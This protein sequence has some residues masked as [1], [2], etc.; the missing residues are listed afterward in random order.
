VQDLA[1][2]FENISNELRHQYN[3]LYRPDPLKTDGLYHKVDIKVR[4]RKELNV[5]A[6]KGYYAPKG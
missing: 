6:R 4:G 3:V 2:S 1:Q 5:R